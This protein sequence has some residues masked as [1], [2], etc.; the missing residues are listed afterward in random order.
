LPTLRSCVDSIAQA[1][2]DPATQISGFEKIETDEPRPDHS[3]PGF[4]GIGIE[5]D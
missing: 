5:R 1:A 2:L 4:I 3:A